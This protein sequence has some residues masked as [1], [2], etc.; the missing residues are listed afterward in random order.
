[1]AEPDELSR[2]VRELADETRA[3]R[4]A[5]GEAERSRRRLVLLFLGILAVGPVLGCGGL[6][7]ARLIRPPDENT[8]ER[9]QR[10]Q[11]EQLDRTDRALDRAEQL[12][13]RWEKAPDGHDGRERHEIGG[14]PLA[15]GASPGGFG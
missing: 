14:W 6:A 11:Q 15:R 1:M 3:L 13:G 9:Q 10:R 2:V 4:A 8:W 12:L 7:V 5:L